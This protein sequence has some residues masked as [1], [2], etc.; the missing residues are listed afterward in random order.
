[1]DDQQRVAA[2]FFEGQRGDRPTLIPF[3]IGPDQARGRC[4]F[5]VATEEL[6]A[7]AL[8]TE[9]QAVPAPTRTSIWQESSEM[10]N[11]F[12]A[13]HRS[14]SSG[15]VQ[16]SNTIRAGPLTVR[17]TSSS[18]SDFRSTVALFFMRVG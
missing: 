6:D 2:R 3:V 7:R 12:G 11:D 17:V 1:M 14:S 18:R 16:A 15:L 8:V 4:H 9:H 10:G 13:H 5:E